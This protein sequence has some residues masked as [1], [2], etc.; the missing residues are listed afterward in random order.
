MR[1]FAFGLLGTIGG[2][3]LGALTGYWL[4]TR[5]SGNSHDRPVE[6]AM[7]SAFVTGPLCAVVGGFV[8]ILLDGR[9]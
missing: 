4:V 8:S 5:T 2:Y 3:V 6:A 1:R 7:T 9:R